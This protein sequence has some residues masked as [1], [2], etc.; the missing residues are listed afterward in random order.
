VQDSWGASEIGERL[1]AILMIYLPPFAPASKRQGIFCLSE[2]DTA[3]I[4]SRG[5]LPTPDRGSCA[6]SSSSSA[7]GQMLY[8]YG[9]RAIS[10]KAKAGHYSSLA[11][12]KIRT[13]HQSKKPRT[14]SVRRF[15]TRCPQAPTRCVQ[16]SY[17]SAIPTPRFGSFTTDAFS[18]RAD[19]CPLLLQ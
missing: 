11:A 10:R 5:K 1:L 8:I 15:L 4:G 17:C 3:F 2:L 14:R 18:T 16:P 9:V 13:R 6:A 12:H 7:A 19:Q